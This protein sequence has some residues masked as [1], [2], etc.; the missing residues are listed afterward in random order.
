[1]RARTVFLLIGLPLAACRN[2]NMYT[3]PKAVTW[4]NSDFFP[5]HMVM[6]HPVPET[7]ARDAPDQ[8]VPQPK[9]MTEAMLADGQERFNADCVPCHDYTGTGHGMIVSRGFPTAANLVS[10]KA[11]KLSARAIYT[12]ITHGV[13]PMVGFGSLIEPEGRWEIVAYIRALQ[14]SQNAPVAS[15]PASDQAKLAEASHDRGAKP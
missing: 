9:I 15:L 10:A 14:L 3:Q 2:E 11:R 7:V 8:P 13:G 12:I 4:G 1:M 5:R 6:R